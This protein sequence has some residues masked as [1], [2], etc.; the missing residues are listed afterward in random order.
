[1]I[2][3][4]SAEQDDIDPWL[5]PCEAVGGVGDAAGAAIVE[6]ETE[7]IWRID[8]PAW[9]LAARRKLAQGG[10]EPLGTREDVAH[11][12]HHEGANAVGDRPRQDAGPGVLVHHVE[13]D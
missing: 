11:R 3:L 12:E 9:Q 5:V 6:E 2:R 10:G 7:R 1:M 4:A 13:R 8:E